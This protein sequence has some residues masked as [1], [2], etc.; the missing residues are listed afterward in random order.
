MS[1]EGMDD[2]GEEEDMFD[3]SPDQQRDEQ[4]HKEGR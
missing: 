3:S 2:D 4:C 1:A